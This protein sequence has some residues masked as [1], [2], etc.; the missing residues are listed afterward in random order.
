[1]SLLESYLEIPRIYRDI[2]LTSSYH[3]ECPFLQ[4]QLGATTIALQ[5]DLAIVGGFGGGRETL[6]CGGSKK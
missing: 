1:M 5:I 3:R 6:H 2:S 4:Q